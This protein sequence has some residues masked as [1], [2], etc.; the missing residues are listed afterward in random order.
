MKSKDTIIT[1]WKNYSTI[2]KLFIM[3]IKI[4][5][6]NLHF[7][8]YSTDLKQMLIVKLILENRKCNL[9][10]WNLESWVI[11][12]AISEFLDRIADLPFEDVFSAF[13]ELIKL[14]SNFDLCTTIFEEAI[15]QRFF[16]VL[17][18][19]SLCNVSRSA[20]MSHRHFLVGA[21]NNDNE[22]VFW[23]KP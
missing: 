12:A 17:L 22:K 21:V 16:D 13:E 19:R 5:L 3:S 6:K 8:M 23:V 1:Q 2:T 18:C 9:D 15:V 7:Y 11:E 4:P 10:L 20:Q 14:L